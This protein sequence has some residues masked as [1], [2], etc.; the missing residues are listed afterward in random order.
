MKQ[1]FSLPN[2]FALLLALVILSMPFQ[3][4]V[5][6]N[7]IA[8]LPVGES[9]DID[10][11]D[12]ILRLERLPYEVTPTPTDSPEPTPSPTPSPVPSIGNTWHSPGSHDGLNAHEHGDEEAKCVKD[13]YAE[14]A[15]VLG[16]D[17]LVYGGDEGTPNENLYKH[18][19]FK[20]YVTD[21]GENQNKN[22]L[23]Y[24]RN[25][26]MDT[27]L[28]VVGVFH[29]MEFYECLNG[30]VVAFVQGW[31]NFAAGDTFTGESTNYFQG[32]DGCDDPNPLLRPFPGNG[33]PVIRVNTLYCQEQG[34][35][36][37]GNWYGDFHPLLPTTGFNIAP[38]YL[39][40]EG[41]SGDPSTWI[42]VEGNNQSRTRRVEIT[43]DP[44]GKPT[45][46]FW[47][48]QFGEI[49]SGPDDARC[50]QVVMA[51]GQPQ[52]VLCLPQYISPN[53][54][55]IDY[56]GNSNAEQRTFPGAGITLPN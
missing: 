43:F 34:I 14:N 2:V 32:P 6:Q 44:L 47:A 22:T 50:G 29:S 39:T 9:I 54:Y 17:H 36:L 56:K 7:N 26:L 20:G 15:E 1:N 4:A 46:W 28:G 48:N 33:R 11:G 8:E 41:E 23:E 53:A 37:F 27:P 12:S 10:L 21:F 30:K 55:L 19:G 13:F 3:G 24:T 42:E 49:V 35:V 31:Q 25:H 18:Q 52:T 16:V 40:F 5:A 45:G 38:S 51:Q